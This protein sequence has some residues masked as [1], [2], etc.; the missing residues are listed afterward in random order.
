MIRC[1]PASPASFSDVFT[2]NNEKQTRSDRRIDDYFEKIRSDKQ[3]KL[4]HEI[5][6][7]IGDKDNMGAKTESGQLA[8]SMAAAVSLI[9]CGKIVDKMLKSK[10]RDKNTT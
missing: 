2:R 6:L 1:T 9:S 5:I 4:F 3:E 7:Q 10:S 8:W